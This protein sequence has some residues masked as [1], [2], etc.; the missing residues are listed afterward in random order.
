MI[1]LESSV[2]DDK[3][4]SGRKTS[5]GEEVAVVPPARVCMV[6][7]F[8]V[9]NLIVYTFLYQLRDKVFPNRSVRTSAFIVIKNDFALGIYLI[10]VLFLGCKLSL[11]LCAFA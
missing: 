10:Y 7:A 8:D 9:T 1:P 3:A 4:C 2:S 6:D 5:F 11:W